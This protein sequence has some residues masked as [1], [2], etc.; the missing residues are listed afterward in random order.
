METSIFLDVLASLQKLFVGYIPAAVLGSVVGYLIGINAPIHQIFKR[1]FQIPHSIP[2]IALLPIAL[3]V[4]GDN[5]EPATVVIVF[6]GTLWSMIINTAIGM[7]H[8]RRQK[9]NFRVAIFHLFHALK[10]GIWIAWFTVIATEMLIGPKGLGFLIWNAYKTG[11]ANDIIE[12]GLYI[13]IIGLLLDQ[14]LDFT[15]NLLSQIVSDG[16]KPS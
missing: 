15:G 2:P 11:N 4:F 8:F 3:V 5:S 16:K 1:L 6:L 13:G 9:N 12:A 14:L 7:Q 10:V